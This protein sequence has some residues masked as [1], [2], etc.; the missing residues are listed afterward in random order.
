MLCHQSIEYDF[1]EVN[2][3]IKSKYFHIV[4][5]IGCSIIIKLF[6]AFN[7]YCDVV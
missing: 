3:A 2:V 6:C 1:L 4:V 7:E 5:R